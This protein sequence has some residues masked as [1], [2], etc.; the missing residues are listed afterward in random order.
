[1]VQGGLSGRVK[2]VTEH[3]LEDARDIPRIQDA[4][5]ELVASR[6]GA[7]LALNVTGGTKPMATGRKR[8]AREPR[9]FT[10]SIPSPPWVD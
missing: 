3:V 2:R 10:S 7:E 5:M 6:E 4:F 8:K 1:M 9:A